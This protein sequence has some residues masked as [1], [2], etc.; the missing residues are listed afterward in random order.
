MV[1]VPILCA[2]KFDLLTLK[3]MTESRV[4]WATSVPILVFLARPLC[5]LC[6][7]LRPDVR[8]RETSDAHHRYHRVA[9]MWV[10]DVMMGGGIITRFLPRDAMNKRSTSLML[11]GVCPFVCSS[12]TFV[13]CIQTTE[14]IVKLLPRPRNPII[15][16][17][18]A[19]RA[20]AQF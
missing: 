5:S 17:S 4:T 20:G 10:D 8:D 15:L 6:S 3:V 19:L 1:V 11:S 7:R 16:V 18:C 12:D 13:Y 14:D 9:M 2:R